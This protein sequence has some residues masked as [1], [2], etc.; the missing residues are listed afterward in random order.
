MQ[1]SKFSDYSFRALIQLASYPEDRWTVDSLAKELHTSIHHM[2]K[3]IYLLSKENYVLA[4]QGRNGELRLGMKPE[5][6]N[7]GTL[8]ELTED[9]LSIVECFHKDTTCP[10]ASKNCKMKKIAYEASKEF[11]NVFHQ[12]T[13]KD[14]L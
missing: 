2:K 3:V 12:Y 6:I 10:L 7:L 13:L 5:D 1:L 11:K 4:R 14:L 9:T 8:L